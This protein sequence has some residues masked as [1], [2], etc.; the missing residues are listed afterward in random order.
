MGAM[1]VMGG[2]F[3][4]VHYGHLLIAEEARI[5]FGLDRIIFVTAGRPPHKKDYVVSDAEHRYAMVALATA[6]N[7]FFECSRMEMDRPGPSYTVDTIETLRSALAP[8]T[9]LYLITGADAI[10]EILTWHEPRRIVSMCKLIAAHRPGYNLGKLK[11]RLPKEI[12]DQV[13]FLETP[14]V[15]VSSTELRARV[16]ESRSIKYMTPE[17][18][19]AY[20]HKHALY[21][22]IK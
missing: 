22:D 11:S 2:T 15:Y 12:S 21:K 17:P 13:I 3:D 6:S 18:V 8:E 7:P 14:G 9:S 5:Q 20:I 1:G 16:R 19:E 10:G 4:P